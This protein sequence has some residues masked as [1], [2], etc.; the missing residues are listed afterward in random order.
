ML[1]RSI[2]PLREGMDR[3]TGR[4]DREDQ[5]PLPHSHSHLLS[6]WAHRAATYGG[7][8]ECTL[9]ELMD[10]PDPDNPVFLLTD[11]STVLGNREKN[12]QKKVFSEEK[13]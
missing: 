4:T 9:A 2:G 11:L 7:L 10:D 12:S 6:L 3:M 5:Q 13:E 1:E 8:T